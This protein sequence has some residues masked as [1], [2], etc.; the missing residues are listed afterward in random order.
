MILIGRQRL[1]GE[2]AAVCSL[3]NEASPMESFI[4]IEQ[5]KNRNLQS[6]LDDDRMRY[7][8]RLSMLATHSMPKGS[9]SSSID[10]ANKVETLR[11]REEVNAAEKALVVHHSTPNEGNA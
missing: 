5:T 11:L 7:E 4:S 8:Q 2:E 1:T 10:I 6:Q 9:G 3:M